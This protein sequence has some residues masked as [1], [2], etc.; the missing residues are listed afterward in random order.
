MNALNILKETSVLDGN[1]IGSHASDNKLVPTISPLLDLTF[2]FPLG[3]SISLYTPREL[4]V[5][6]C[7]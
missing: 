1:P 2:P 6:Y 7:N 5:E 4:K 3:L